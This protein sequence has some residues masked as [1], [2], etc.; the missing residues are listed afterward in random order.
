MKNKIVDFYNNHKQIGL[1][2]IVLGL[3]FF[4]CL[5]VSFARYSVDLIKNRFFLT[6]NFYFSSNKLKEE[7][8]EYIIEHW[9]GTSQYDIAISMQN[10]SNLL[11]KTSKDISYSISCETLSTDSVNATDVSCSLPDDG[12]D[13]KILKDNTSDSFIVSLNYTGSENLSEGDSIKV[14]V[15]A[16]SSDPYIKT[17]SATFELFVGYYGITYKIEDKTNQVYFMSVITNAKNFYVVQ[18]AFTDEIGSF[19]ENRKIDIDVY[20]KLSDENKKNCA[21]AIIKLEW[22]VNEVQLDTTN[23]QYLNRD[24]SHD[25]WEFLQN[26]D[27][28]DYI[29]ALQFNMNAESSV[30][31]KFYKT[32][33]ANN[34][35]YPEKTGSPIVTYQ[36]FVTVS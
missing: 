15:T 30:A 7:T 18:N 13:R 27:G 36:D 31:V 28:A 2:L 23:Y 24:T 16:T 17:L 9:S 5:F 3:I 33:V 20:N 10:T 14:K 8:A 34:Y 21:S 25:N 19:E 32:R 11:L 35:S 22:N 26:V 29:K 4:S 12:L 6:Q 1:I